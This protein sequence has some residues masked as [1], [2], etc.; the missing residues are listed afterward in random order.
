[1]KGKDLFNV[2]MKYFFCGDVCWLM[3]I[4]KIDIIIT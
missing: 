3:M 1:M 4:I 2:N